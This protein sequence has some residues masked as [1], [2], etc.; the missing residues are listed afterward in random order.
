MVPWSFGLYH[1]TARNKGVS[2]AYLCLEDDRVESYGYK[3]AKP[4]EAAHQKSFLSCLAIE[5]NNGFP[6]KW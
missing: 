2:Y 6:Q 3:L 4:R 5:S 1:V